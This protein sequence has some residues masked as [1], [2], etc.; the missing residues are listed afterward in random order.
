M[1]EKVKKF[2]KENSEELKVVALVAAC[3]AVSCYIGYRSAYSKCVK[4]KQN[5]LNYLFEHPEGYKLKNSEDL[6]TYLLSLTKV[7]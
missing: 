4:Y 1:K 7:A 5:I 6:C 3:S 2:F